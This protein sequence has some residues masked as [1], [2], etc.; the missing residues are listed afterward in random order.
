MRERM[1]PLPLIFLVAGTRVA[2]DVGLSFLLAGKMSRAARRWMEP[3]GSRR[4]EYDPVGDG[5]TRVSR[6]SRVCLIGRS[7]HS[8]E[9]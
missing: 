7:G 2:L 4:I 5:G 8:R 1:V 3:F 9:A 6:K